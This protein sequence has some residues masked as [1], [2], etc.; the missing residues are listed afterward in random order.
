MSEVRARPAHAHAA[1]LDSTCLLLLAQGTKPFVV[2]DGGS[3]REID[4]DDQ[5]INEVMK[6]SLATAVEEQ[7]QRDYQLARELAAEHSS[8]DE[9]IRPEIVHDGGIEISKS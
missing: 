4:P 8:L 5:V 7:K 9:P 2:Y 6:K 3:E 1:G